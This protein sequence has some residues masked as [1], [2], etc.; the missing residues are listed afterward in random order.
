[1]PDLGPFIV[2]GLAL[3][4]VYALSG[5]GLVVLHRTTGVV[6]FAYGATG[7][8]GALVAWSILESGGAEPVAWA[9][10]VAAAVALS[11]L[12]GVTVAA[13]L[14]QRDPAVQAAASLGFTL[15]LLGLAILLWRD[16]PRTFALP[17]DQWSRDVLGV[18]V[19]A[20]K[21]LALGLAVAVTAVVAVLLRRTR[22]GLALRAM[23]DDREL[24]GLLGV[25]VVRLG[26]VAW[27]LSGALAGVSGLLV[28]DLIRLDAG[29]LTFLVV[30]G[31]AAAIVGHLS[32]LPWTL[33]GGLGIG[34]VEAL[35]TP[36]D[37]LTSYRGA[38]PFAVAIGFLLWHQRRRGAA[39]RIG[40]A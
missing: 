2:T 3:G 8:I 28:A 19:V 36:F 30:P 27:A 13:R 26:A 35:A 24:S 20:T 34:L 38:A 29:T 21:P 22:G 32:S 17:T 14:A 6:N 16:E 18:T 9:A 7:A 40:V 4:A 12:Y 25:P 10:A 31:I 33:A 5:V 37:S 11:V 15:V 23:A 1:M 39:T